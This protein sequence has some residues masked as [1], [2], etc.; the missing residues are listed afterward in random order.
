M[1]SFLLTFCVLYRPF[2]FMLNWKKSFCADYTKWLWQYALI[3]LVELFKWQGYMR[4]QATAQHQGRPSAVSCC[5]CAQLFKET[6]FDNRAGWMNLLTL[7]SAISIFDQH[8]SYSVPSAEVTSHVIM[9][10]SG[11]PPSVCHSIKWTGLATARNHTAAQHSPS[12]YLSNCILLLH[13]WSTNP[14]MH[15]Y[16]LM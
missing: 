9:N 4:S 1:K 15:T 12:L 10:S 2:I 13:A 14:N 6:S 16:M 7:S 11:P 3:I 8:R 5:P